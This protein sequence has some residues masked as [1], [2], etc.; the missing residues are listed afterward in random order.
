MVND[1][2]G[3]WVE[4]WREAIWVVRIGRQH[5]GYAVVK[6]L[7]SAVPGGGAVPGPHSNSKHF[8]NGQNCIKTRQAVDVNSATRS[9]RS[10]SLRLVPEDES[11]LSSYTRGFPKKSWYHHLGLCIQL[12]PPSQSPIRA[13]KYRTPWAT[14]LPKS[15]LAL[16]GLPNASTQPLPLPPSSPLPNL[17]PL[18]RQR[19]SDHSQRKSLLRAVAR[20]WSNSTVAIPSS[21]QR[22][23]A[24][25]QHDECRNRL[26][27]D[28]QTRYRSQRFRHHRNHLNF[29]SRHLASQYSRRQILRLTQPW[30]SCKPAT[31]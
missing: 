11:Q 9:T 6:L 5:L 19:R 29:S 7:V 10:L 17:R 8:G 2:V 1:V 16:L 20:R 12:R 22:C 3:E 21:V 26:H 14:P 18:H 31:A 15:P 4:R 13:S 24:L 27:E 23:P 30:R 25:A 28:P